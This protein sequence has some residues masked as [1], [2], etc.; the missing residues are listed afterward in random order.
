VP[1]GFSQVASTH[2]DA[3]ALTELAL[4]VAR[5]IRLMIMLYTGQIDV[6]TEYMLEVHPRVIDP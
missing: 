3:P 6:D 4:P 1:E 5:F 2:S